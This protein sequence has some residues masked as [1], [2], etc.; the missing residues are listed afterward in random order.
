M[1]GDTL[2][3]VTRSLQADVN[4]FVIEKLY[5][6]LGSDRFNTEDVLSLLIE[7][8]RADNALRARPTMG[9][10]TK[11]LVN[12]QEI[13]REGYAIELGIIQDM[14]EAGDISRPEARLLRRNV[15]VMQVDADSGI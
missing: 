8:Q 7:H 14:L 6:E 1:N 2:F 4:R 11:T 13:K 9:D 5:V 3:A 12:V 15:Y 10:T